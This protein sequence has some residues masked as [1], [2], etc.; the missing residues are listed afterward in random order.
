MC[1][2][3][4]YS[5]SVPLFCLIMCLCGSQM[6]PNFQYFR[7][8]GSGVGASAVAPGGAQRPV[9]L[10]HPRGRKEGTR[11]VGMGGCWSWRASAHYGDW[12]CSL[13]SIWVK[14]LFHG[15]HGCVMF[16][17]DILILNAVSRNVW[18]SSPGGWYSECLCYPPCSYSLGI[19]Y[20]I[21]LG[22]KG[23]RFLNLYVV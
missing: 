17:L 9:A 3:V 18:T 23:I 6:A 16:S 21:L 14:G 7:F 5:V 22:S 19:G 4:L 10:H 8:C 11:T 20:Q 15:G 2:S 13:S 12:T 1:F